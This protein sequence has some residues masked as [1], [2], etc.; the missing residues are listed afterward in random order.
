MMLTKVRKLSPMKII[1]LGY[2]F[3]ILIGA[4]LLA[5]P[6]SVKGQDPTNFMDAVMTATSATCVTGL[7][8]FDT[9]THWSLFGQLVI[10]CL[11]QIGGIGFMTMAVSIISLTKKKIGLTP[12][13]L[14]QEAIS[15]PQVGGI[16]RMTK[17]IFQGTALVEGIG[18]LLLGFYF[19]PRLGFWKGVYFSIFHSISA[20]CNAGFDLMGS[21]E[22]YSSLTSLSANWYVN[23]IIMA[24]IIIGGLG[25]F[26]WGDLLHTKF[27]FRK[28]R[29]HTKLVLTVSVS[30]IILGTLGI[31][32][33]EQGGAGFEGKTVSDQV[34]ASMF[35]SVSARTAG[36]NT[37]DLSRITEASQFLILCLMLIGG[38]AG[39]TAGG[40]KTTT[41]AILIL[42]VFS[43]FHRKKSVEGFGRR[44]DEETLRRA[45]C[46]FMMYLLL[47]CVS[48][49]IISNIEGLPMMASLFEC[50][51]A[52]GTVGLS[53]GVTP[54]VGIL[55]QIILSLLM[56]FG[57]A[58]SITILLAF[59][60][61]KSTPVSKLPLEKIQIG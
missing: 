7:I 4:L 18:A 51:S 21:V 14:A 25:F 47:S 32:L 49:M 54:T 30:L 28:M 44:T 20:F 9:Y 59:S 58:G 34:L 5:L 55:S 15:A 36:F 27:H 46:I 61:D 16:V 6:V 42:S 50:V 10:L 40:I 3:L 23:S 41:F 53:F 52:I 37:V 56:L 45:S 60:S 24:L 11:I 39:S 38:S 22:P 12:R 57:R 17:F 48:A 43:T 8:R 2:C 31:F 35:Q 29:L 33:L 19:C 26:V 1:L 13:V